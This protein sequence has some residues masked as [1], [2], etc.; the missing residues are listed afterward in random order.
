MIL[1]KCFLLFLSL[2]LSL[3][4]NVGQ[5]NK[6]MAPDAPG[7][8][9]F[10]NITAL[11]ETSL[12]VFHVTDIEKTNIPLYFN[13]RTKLLNTEDGFYLCTKELFNDGH[14]SNV[15]QFV[16]RYENGGPQEEIINKLLQK[17]D[18]LSYN[19]TDTGVYCIYTHENHGEGVSYKIVQPYGNLSIDSAQELDVLMFVLLPI[20]LAILIF[21]AFRYWRVLRNIPKE[22][23][24]IESS[25]ISLSFSNFLYHDNKRTVLSYLNKNDLSTSSKFL[26]LLFKLGGFFGIFMMINIF[27]FFY[28]WTQSPQ[29]KSIVKTAGPGT[30]KFI[31]FMLGLYFMSAGF[32]CIFPTKDSTP[33]FLIS[34]IPL[35]HYGEKIIK[36]I[37]WLTLI[38]GLN[39]T[40]S[41]AADH[42]AKR[43]F[44][45]SRQ[46]TISVPLIMVFTSIFCQFVISFD[47]FARTL[48]KSQS[49]ESVIVNVL[50]NTV[51][52]GF[53]FGLVINLGYFIVP[54]IIIGLI[55][56]W[57]M[58]YGNQESTLP[59]AGEIELSQFLEDDED[60]RQL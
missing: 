23:R 48:K 9:A 12:L 3:A 45:L 19:V 5:C 28:L 52:Y 11:Q 24:Q 7:E 1:I 2:S 22:D 25:L 34:F 4:K 38:L 30:G 37:I 18:T 14:C 26:V 29:G 60:K 36:F 32:F 57:K 27:W 15:G 55:Y 43:K 58:D 6:I 20:D 41:K 31:R 33:E 8:T 10:I 13:D 47:T 53:V 54:L 40:V 16:I 44:E 51:H 49:N 50:E 46:L 39:R 59:D 35:F 17:G 42:K 56:I 21:W